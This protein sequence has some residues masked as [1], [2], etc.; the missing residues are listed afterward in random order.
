MTTQAEQVSDGNHRRDQGSKLWHEMIRRLGSYSYCT[1]LVEVDN[2]Q[3]KNVAMSRNEA[4]RHDYDDR[5]VSNS[6]VVS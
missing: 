4:S 6:R 5:T 1:R 2:E 3:E